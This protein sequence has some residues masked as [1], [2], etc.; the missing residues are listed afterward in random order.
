MNARKFNCH[1]TRGISE[2][3]IKCL[4][5]LRESGVYE[6]E[7]GA[8]AGRVTSLACS[9]SAARPLLKRSSCK[10][11]LSKCAR[12]RL[13]NPCSLALNFKHDSSSSHRQ[14]WCDSSSF[15]RWLLA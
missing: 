9:R 7:P 11:R 4:S 13:T 5:V 10:W 3:R 12:W 6:A 14:R 8:L 2:Q 15:G 1:I